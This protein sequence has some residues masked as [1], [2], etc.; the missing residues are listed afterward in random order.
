M[1]FMA[2]KQHIIEKQMDSWRNH[3]G[4]KI[5]PTTTWK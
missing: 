4:N 1:Q 3:D 2:I 5:I